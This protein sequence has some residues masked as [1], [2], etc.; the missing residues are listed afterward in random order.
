M[1]SILDKVK[2]LAIKNGTATET[3]IKVADSVGLKANS[4]SGCMA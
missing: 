4:D 2:E 1:S 3:T